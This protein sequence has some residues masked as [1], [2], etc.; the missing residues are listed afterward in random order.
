MDITD[1]SSYLYSI[2]PTWKSGGYISNVSANKEGQFSKKSVL[3]EEDELNEI[4]DKTI[5]IYLEAFDNLRNNNFDINPK[6][7]DTCKY[8][9]YKHIC[10]VNDSQFRE[11]KEKNNE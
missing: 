10:Y 8:C 7:K 5:S 4:V 1:K 9:S 11:R 2:D 3:Y 6:N